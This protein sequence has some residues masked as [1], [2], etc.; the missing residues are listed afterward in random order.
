MMPAMKVFSAEKANLVCFVRFADETQQEVF[1]ENTFAHYQSL[2]ND[3]ATGAI[4]VY[5]YFL[6]SSYG[7]LSWKSSF[8]PTTSDGCIVSYQTKYS[9]GFFQEKDNLN[10]SGYDADD[11]VTKAARERALI[12]DITN[13]INENIPADVIVDA[14][15]DGFVD[16]VTIILSGTSDISSRHLLWPHRSDLVSSDGTYQILG[17]KMISYLLVFDESNGFNFSKPGNTRIPLNAGV[18]CH[19][20]SHSLG[21][22]DLYHVNDKLNP[23]GIWDL[24]SDNQTIPQQMTAY[25]KWRYCKWI[26]EIPEITSPGTYTLN[27][28]GG[29]TSKNI[30]YKIKEV[31]KDE[32]FIVEYRK[33]EGFDA[34]LPESGMIVY[35]INPAYSGGNLNYNGTT[36]LDEV[37]VFRPNG[38][39][40][41]D[42]NILQAALSADN[43][44]NAFGG[45]VNLKPFYSN[46]EEANIAITDITSCGETIS[47]TLMPSED[48]IVLSEH[49]LRLKGIAKA[50][51]TVTISSDLDWAIVNLPEWLS[52]TPASGTKG[53]T[54]IVIS[55]T[56]ENTDSKQR[57][58]TLYIKGG[59]LCDSI[60]VIQTS[61]LISPPAN[62]CAED[63]GNAVRLTWTMDEKG[64]TLI[65]DGFEDESNPV[66]WTIQ[67]YGDRGWRF[68][69]GAPDKKGMSMVHEGTHAMLMLD[70]WDDIHQ[71]EYLTS[72]VFSRGKTLSFYSH[73]NGGNAT[74]VVLPYYLIEVSSDA[75]QTWHQIFNVIGDYPRDEQGNTISAAVGYIPLTFDLTP[76]L[77]ETMQ[78]R[79]HCYDTNNMGLSYWWQIDDLEIISADSDYPVT[80]YNVYRNGI[81]IAEGITDKCY[82]DPLPMNGENVYSVSAATSLGESAMSETVTITR[83]YNTKG[84]ANT[85]GT[86]DVADITAIASYILGNTPIPFNTSNADVD[87]DGDITVADITATAGIILK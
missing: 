40:T 71:D 9:R 26:D 53:R 84:D 76:Y 68:M 65:Y 20:M 33:R 4:S 75:G 77:S 66:G 58:A 22:Y 14:D 48:K 50:A 1:Q 61:N 31:S 62:L 18:L 35:R 73:T 64:K 13:Y 5:N 55:T 78:I 46:G 25:T 59:E 70:S 29:S 54:E 3:D 17:K 10:P 23:V 24:M 47:F 15:N 57:E 21:T 45:D 87:N 44:R 32:Y 85:D 42:G 52:A 2:F 27:P 67:N 36:R 49:Q 8:F 81:R 34:S 12:S 7:K 19:E 38:T 28:V 80:G 69:T 86:I 60:H 30:A 74:P 43:G 63:E 37:Y 56:S 51:A 39:T 41:K 11:E 16:N 72:P 79:F 83:D 82:T 6:T